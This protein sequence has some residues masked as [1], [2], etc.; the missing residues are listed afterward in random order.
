VIMRET[1][2]CSIIMMI[3][4]GV[5]QKQSRKSVRVNKKWAPHFLKVLLKNLA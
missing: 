3:K 4:D 2:S 5:F 1:I